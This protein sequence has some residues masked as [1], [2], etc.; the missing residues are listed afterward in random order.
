MTI[1]LLIIEDN[2]NDVELFKYTLKKAKLDFVLKQ[3]ETEEELLKELADSPPDL[4][5]SD[6]SLPRLDGSFALD[7]VQSNRPEIPFILL[8]GGATDERIQAMKEKGAAYCLS[9][10]NL[11]LVPNLILK[12]IETI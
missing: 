4:I 2:K 12:F 6:N 3:V 10:D 8:S 9:K 7:L 5:F 1:R 11:D